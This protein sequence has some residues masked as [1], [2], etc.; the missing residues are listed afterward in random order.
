M[1]RSKTSFSKTKSYKA[2]ANFLDSHSLS[3]YWDKTKEAKFEVQID[4][5][6]TYYSL[7]GRLSKLIQEVARRR[8]MSAHALV[9]TWVREKLLE[10]KKQRRSVL[11][12]K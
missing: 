3:S 2:V 12:L 4:S 11:Q 6:Q 9:N 8:G 10:Q 1:N 5:E 7:E